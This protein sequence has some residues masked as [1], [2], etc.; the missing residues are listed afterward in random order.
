MGIAL[1]LA[2][3]LPW[4]G[5]A[6]F[7][8]PGE[9]QHAAIA[10][11]ALQSRDFVTLRLNGVPYFDKPPALYGLVA[12]G[13]A[14]AGPAEW[15]A[16]LAPVTGAALAVAGAIAL[17]HRLLG[18]PWGSLA[19]VALLGAPLFFAFGAYLRPE[20]L[21]VA[22]VQWG[23]AGLC[24]AAVTAPEH[25]ARARRWACLG[26]AALGA[27]ALV[28]DPLALI[29]PPAVCALACW[30]GRRPVALRACFHPGA[31]AL[32]LG[33]GLS[34]YVAAAL[35][36][37]GFAWYV[38][39]DNHALNALGVRR[40]PDEDVSLSGA[41]FLAVSAMGI[42]PWILPAAVHVG[43]LLARRAWRE[44]AELPWVALAVWTV[45]LLA[46]FAL[47]RFK[48]PH[49]AL[50]AYPAIAL[51]AVREW[52]QR[53]D[54]PG[55]LVPVHVAAFAGVAL[56][57]GVIAAGDG[58][59]LMATVVQ[60]ADVYA[61]K[62]AAI[63]QAAPFPA[64]RDLQPL[65]RYTAVVA[66]AGALALVALA[67]RP[68][69]LAAVVAITMLALTPAVGAA[70]TRVA[71]ARSVVGL[72]ALAAR[73]TRDG[74]VLVHEGPIENSGALSLYAARRPVLLEGRRSVLGF[75]ATRPE[76]RELFWDAD[77]FHA[78]WKG[79]RTLVVVT[80]RAPAL[81]LV[82]AVPPG[83]RRLLATG[84]GRWLYRIGCDGPPG[85]GSVGR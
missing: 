32:G 73:E 1:T 64:W 61:R 78:E 15:A 8:D 84:N 37:P 55:W 26:W 83:H 60:S 82:S 5:A 13:F 29:G 34:W 7:D 41:E 70:L 6:P 68:R 18:P 53:R 42:F 23:L 28:K 33:I 10:F 36:N 2:L 81:S 79:G 25:P 22:A 11:E 46:V 67:R 54:Q 44:R 56:A 16:R 80:P 51:L 49:Y 12:A 45:A 14:A 71:A 59:A 77:R 27:G 62:E 31:V 17:G 4:I 20:T 35:V 58:H 38:A 57:A 69:S 50:P 52:S 43:R 74:A 48:L 19:G 9:G 65:V 66:G 3:L 21:F 30:L 72:A 39:V 40:F 85:C 75:G 76:A 63:G 47:S 24:L